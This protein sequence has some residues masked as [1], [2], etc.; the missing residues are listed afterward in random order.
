MSVDA[1]PS[2]ANIIE[3][4][5]STCVELE[6]LTSDVV[7]EGIAS[8]HITSGAGTKQNETMTSVD[9]DDLAEG[10]ATEVTFTVVSANG[11][12]PSNS[13]VITIT[14]LGAITQADVATQS[15]TVCLG[16]TL[17]TLNGNTLQT[18]ETA[19]WSTTTSGATINP[20][21][22]EVTSLAT[23]VN[24]FTYTIVQGGNCSDSDVVTITSADVPETS[25]FNETL[26]ILCMGESYNLTINPSALATSYAWSIDTDAQANTTEAFSSSF[27][28][29]G[30]FVVSVAAVNACGQDPTPTQVTVQVIT[31][32]VLNL[33]PL[34][35]TCNSSID[36][37]D[38]V[39]SVTPSSAT[40]RYYND[41]GATSEMLSTVVSAVGTNTYYVQAQ[42][43]TCTST[44]E[45]VLTTINQKPS[46]PQ[47]TYQPVCVG[48]PL[49]LRVSSVSTVDSYNWLDASMSSIGTGSSMMVS[50]QAATAHEGQYHL[51]S[52]VGG[53]HSDTSSVTVTLETTPEPVIN[54]SGLG[55]PNGTE[56]SLCREDL[57]QTLTVTNTSYTPSW[58]LDG[59]STS[60]IASVNNIGE[61]EVFVSNGV[62][63]GTAT[64]TIVIDEFELSA[65]ADTYG[66][67]E[68][69]SVTL[70]A[71]GTNMVESSL[72]WNIVN[73]SEIGTGTPVTYTPSETQSYSVVGVGTNNCI[74]T[75]LSLIHI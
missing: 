52:T 28:S 4:D 40:V 21:T 25:A 31:A 6:A 64:V 30:S 2:T 36:I 5:F 53:C 55:L 66:V 34:A 3:S 65:Y 39:T 15:A 59:N 67:E 9:I 54:L 27:S 74:D 44:V 56:V 57:P 69:G 70:Y 37:S 47:A 16:G 24:E 29:S 58:T 46:T 19:S 32:P 43:G 14:R 71:E 23:G 38:A 18:G 12:C 75:A 10:Q 11:Y 42:E 7:T 20:T 49:E 13:D 8:W 60:P 17:P 51:Y 61:F 41:N 1:Q 33:S 68:G 73:G 45:S 22:G 62:C 48:S 72:V 50:N 35:S 63:T 26:G